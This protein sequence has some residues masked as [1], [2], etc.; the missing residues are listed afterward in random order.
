MTHKHTHVSKEARVSVAPFHPTY[1]KL[2]APR[3]FD[4]FR[5]AVLDV[6]PFEIIELTLDGEMTPRNFQPVVAAALSPLGFADGEWAELSASV[7]SAEEREGMAEDFKETLF[8]LAGKAMREGRIYPYMTAWAEK[9][10]E[11]ELSQV[12]WEGFDH[13]AA[14]RD[15]QEAMAIEPQLGRLTLMQMGVCLQQQIRQSFNPD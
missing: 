4:E 10:A 5:A 12:S 11:R 3:T 1:P 15:V 13:A 8:S 6:D 2:P 7:L 14:K 9:V